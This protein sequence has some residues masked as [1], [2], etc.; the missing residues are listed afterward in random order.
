MGDICS[1]HSALI[2]VLEDCRRRLKGDLIKNM[3]LM[4]LRFFQLMVESKSFP[5]FQLKN[6]GNGFK[7]KKINVLFQSIQ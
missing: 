4:L 5:L 6:I 7:T 2:Q 1:S 3:S